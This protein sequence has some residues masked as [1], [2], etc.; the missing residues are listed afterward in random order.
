M[1]PP[2]WPPPQTHREKDENCE[3]RVISQYTYLITFIKFVSYYNM[4]HV[5]SY[6]LNRNQVHSVLPGLLLFTNFASFLWRRVG[7]SRQFS[8]FASLGLLS[9]IKGQCQG[10]SFDLGRLFFI[11]FLLWKWAVKKRLHISA[12]D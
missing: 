4:S 5:T 9:V 8:S 1:A 2:T 3:I 6:D 12:F 10:G 11:N 7:F